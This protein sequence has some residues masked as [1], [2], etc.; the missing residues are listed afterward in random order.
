MAQIL[1]YHTK[2]IRTLVQCSL[3]TKHRVA[4]VLENPGSHGIGGKNSKPW[5]V[6]KFG[7]LKIL[8]VMELGVNI[9]GPRKYL[10]LCQ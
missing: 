3:E 5:K 6:L 10:N 8:E 9:T 2:D 7:S 1:L 4:K